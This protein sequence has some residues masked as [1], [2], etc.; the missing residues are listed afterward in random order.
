[1]ATLNLPR[2]TTTL[3]DLREGIN[4]IAILIGDYATLNATASPSDLVIEITAIQSDIG[5]LS[6][7]NTV[8]KSSLVA[9][10][11]EVLG[12]LGTI[13]SQNSSNVSITGGTISGLTS[14]SSTSISATTI[15]SSLIPSDSFTLGSSGV[16]WATGYAST[17]DANLLIV[18]NYVASSLLPITTTTYDI[19]NG[20]Y[21]WN[22]IYS[23]TVNSS[24]G[25]TIAQAQ[26]LILDT[27]ADT[28]LWSN[29]DDVFELYTGA[30]KVV[31]TTATSISNNV[32]TILGSQIVEKSGTISTGTLNLS[33]GNY[34]EKAMTGDITFVFSTT[35]CN[36]SAGQVYSFGLM[37]TGLTTD[38][39]TWPTVTWVS[40]SAPDLSTVTGKVFLS[41][42]T[43]DQGT[44]WY[45]SIPQE[46]Q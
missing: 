12:G 20:T 42:Y 43:P 19:G 15:G 28:Y 46:F 35:N 34:F 36:W 8:A 32:K 14:L 13:S 24:G 18:N 45:G 16:R 9:A 3:N 40:G 23:N 1:M 44:T 10:I 4:S 37:L 38:T 6:T 5:T 27:D 31:N 33:T 29:G 22:G 26:K 21:R 25:I 11:N 39:I 41:F 7:L 17:I 2:S 30:V